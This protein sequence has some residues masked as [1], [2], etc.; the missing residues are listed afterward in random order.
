MAKTIRSH[1]TSQIFVFEPIFGTTFIFLRF[2]PK[3]D[4]RFLHFPTSIHVK[5]LAPKGNKMRMDQ[6]FILGICQ[7]LTFDMIFT[8]A[9]H[10]FRKNPL[11]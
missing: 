3:M 11:S 10:L 1:P 9:F 6:P 8:I 7:N 2:G 4:L 5:R